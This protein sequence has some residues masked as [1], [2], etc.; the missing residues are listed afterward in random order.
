MTDEMRPIER[1]DFDRVL[2]VI[3]AVRAYLADPSVPHAD[4]LELTQEQGNID[5]AALRAGP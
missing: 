5:V 1:S 2:S 3:H 4:V